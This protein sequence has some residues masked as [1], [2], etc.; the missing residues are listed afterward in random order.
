MLGTH[1]DHVGMTVGIPTFR[2]RRVFKIRIRHPRELGVRMLHFL[3]IRVRVG[4]PK[5]LDPLK[6]LQPDGKHHQEPQASKD[7]AK[8]KLLEGWLHGTVSGNLDP[9]IQIRNYAGLPG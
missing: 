6:I 2:G 9:E 1:L 4:D 8:G 7:D 3:L 5:L